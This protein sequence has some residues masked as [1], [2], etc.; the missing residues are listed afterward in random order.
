ML[1]RRDQ[2]KL[3]EAKQA[4]KQAKK[5]T[6]AAEPDEG[7]DREPEH[8]QKKPRRQRKPKVDENQPEENKEPQE[9]KP[10]SKSVSR[11]KAAPKPA[12]EPVAVAD[13]PEAM[14]DE[15]VPGKRRA[16]SKSKAEPKDPKPKKAPKNADGKSAA[17]AKAKSS[18][19]KSKTG[20]KAKALADANINVEQNSHEEDEI[21]A[22][23]IDTATPKKKLFQ[24][25]EETGDEGGH[26]SPHERLDSKTGEVKPLAAIFEQ[27]KPSEWIATRPRKKKVEKKTKQASA[28]STAGAAASSNEA[29]GKPAKAKAKS[30]KRSKQ[31]LSPFAKKENKRR[32]QA[33]LATMQ[34]SPQEDL[35]V[36]GIF[37][38]YMKQCKDLTYDGLKEYLY[39]NL[40]HQFNHGKLN[41]YFSRP[42]C[43]VQV[44][45]KTGKPGKLTEIVYFGRCGTANSFNAIVVTAYVSGHLMAFWLNGLVQTNYS[46]MYRWNM[47]KPFTT[48]HGYPLHLNVEGLPYLLTIEDLLSSYKIY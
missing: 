41:P 29:G 1:T 46:I 45:L 39:K 35:Q 22:G 16:R 9:S 7:G 43:G 40:P 12:A 17:K 28:A 32:K 5:K 10:P 42:A 21:V 20:R 34:E 18:A 2:L 4:E 27:D 44:D 15:A 3:K 23:E 30:T 24:S 8:V 37:L 13:V 14:P 38:Q 19:A 33:E 36:Q 31:E 25:D 48:C 11:R 26:D 6:K 47:V